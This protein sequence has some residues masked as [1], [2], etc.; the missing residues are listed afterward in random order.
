MAEMRWEEECDGEN[1]MGDR[2]ANICN[3]IRSHRKYLR[4]ID[5]IHLMKLRCAISEICDERL[6]GQRSV[7]TPNYMGTGLVERG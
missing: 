7:T 2:I 1:A 6:K 5:G 4:W 3:A